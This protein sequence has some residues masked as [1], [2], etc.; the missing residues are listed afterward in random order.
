MAPGRL[1]RAQAL[2]LAALTFAG[3]EK[4]HAGEIAGLPPALWPGID[5]DFAFNFSNDF[6]GRGGSVDDFRTQQI[7]VSA[8]LDDRFSVYVDHSIL[9][10]T[11]AD[12]PG[13]IDQFAASVGYQLIDTGQVSVTTG[14]GIR[15]VGDFGGDRMQNGFHR[16]IGSD[17]DDLQYTGGEES[18]ATLWIDGSYRVE[19]AAFGGW[20]FGYWLRGA[21]LVSSAGEWDGTLA[22]LATIHRG[23]VDVWTGLRYDWRSGYGDDAVLAAT[24]AAE[25][26]AAFVL[27]LRFGALVLETVQQFDNDASYG[28][29]ML[30]ADGVRAGRAT[31][32][33]RQNTID[34]AVLVPDVEVRLAGK[35]RSNFFP[36]FS[37]NWREAVYLEMRYGEP[38][39]K[40]DNTAYV[41]SLQFGAGLEWESPAAPAAGW[42]RYYASAGVGWR[43]EQLKRVG[44]DT[45]ASSDSVHRGAFLAGAGLRILA[46]SLGSRAGYRLQMGI[47]TVIPFGDADVIVNGTGFTLMEPVISANLGMSFDFD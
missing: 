8:K 19:F 27:G 20:G 17:I 39:Y 47:N 33:D 13:R 6:L 34:F 9:T 26:D 3:A 38:Q 11:N 29:L 37:A 25:E 30:V 45:V 46:T 21:T 32:D 42:L 28:Q 5:R 44:N 23:P 43:S 7:V 2:I 16:L 4:L 31:P 35:R 10:L 18:D 36:G 24:A 22:A 14:A 41:E 1:L 12:A 15:S 40:S